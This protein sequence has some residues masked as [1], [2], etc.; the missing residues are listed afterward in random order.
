MTLCECKKN[1][2]YKVVSIV[3]YD[4]KLKLRLYEVG[5]FPGS[6]IK[7]LNKSFSNKT[8]LVHVL[9]SC[10]AMQSDIANIVEVEYG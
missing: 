7:I 5:F 8:I 4:E 1:V 6:L 3:S 9:D 2:F 10:F